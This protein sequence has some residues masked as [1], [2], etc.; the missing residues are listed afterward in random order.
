[1][2][3]IGNLIKKHYTTEQGFKETHFDQNQRQQI[4]KNIVKEDEIN[5][6]LEITEKN[7]TGYLNNNKA[8]QRGIRLN[9]EEAKMIMPK[10]KRYL[11][12]DEEFIL[13][14][15]GSFYLEGQESGK[16]YNT[17]PDQSRSIRDN[18]TRLYPNILGYKNK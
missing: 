15:N 7:L 16:I 1:M 5:Q 8:L 14:F 13:F 2:Q 10:G 6:Q 17:K 3:K 18:L 12:E 9:K 11:K 4:K